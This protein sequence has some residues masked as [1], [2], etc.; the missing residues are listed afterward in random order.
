MFEFLKVSLMLKK[1]G[2]PWFR[3]HNVLN[4]FL[5]SLSGK[6]NVMGVTYCFRKDDHC[7][8]VMPYM[9]HQ[10]FVVSQYC[11]LVCVF[12]PCL[13]HN[14]SNVMEIFLLSGYHWPAEFRGGASVYLPPA[15]SPP[16][17]PPV[18]HHPP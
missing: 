13:W 11:Y 5:P 8:I 1:V 14:T 17:H 12:I 10:T 2:D 4:V 7:V 18:W 16:T 3:Q 9:E 6:E 15:E